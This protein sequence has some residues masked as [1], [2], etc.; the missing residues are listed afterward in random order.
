MFL[1]TLQLFKYNSD[2]SAS[3]AL[4]RYFGGRK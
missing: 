3:G 4:V 2:A 1:T